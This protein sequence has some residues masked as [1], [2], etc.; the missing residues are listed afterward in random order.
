MKNKKKE[1]QMKTITLRQYY[2]AQMLSGTN[3]AFPAEE[4]GEELLGGFWGSN[5][6][7]RIVSTVDEILRMTGDDGD[8]FIEDED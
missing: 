6:A 1:E 5:T 8:A 3:A 4:S 7:S 2:I